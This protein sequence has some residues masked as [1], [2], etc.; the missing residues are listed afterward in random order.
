M[1]NLHRHV[2]SMAFLFTWLCAV[3]LSAV[4]FTLTDTLDSTNLTSLRGA[5]VAANLLGGTNTILL[6][7]SAYQLTIPGADEDAAITGDLDITNGKLSILGVSA[8]NATVDATGLGD[9]VF[10][11]LP[12]AQLVL[13]NLVVS[14]GTG[15]DGLTNGDSGSPGGGIYNGGTLTLIHC[16]LRGNSGGTGAGGVGLYSGS[17]AGGS[18]GAIYSLGALTLEECL[19]TAV[20]ILGPAGSLKGSGGGVDGTVG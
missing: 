20:L 3:S 11:V 9:R 19:V 5:I 15:R 7:S 4:T 10:H 18:G 16:V 2:T 14:G 1:D 8:T 13:S 17:G 12:G 6:T